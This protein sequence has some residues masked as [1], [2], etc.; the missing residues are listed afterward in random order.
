MNNGTPTPKTDYEKKLFWR[1]VRLYLVWGVSFI[2]CLILS[3]NLL[4]ARFLKQVGPQIN[5]AFAQIANLLPDLS[6]NEQTLTK[7]Y[8][9]MTENRNSA[10]QAGIGLSEADLESIGESVDALI[11]GC[12]DLDR[13]TRVKVGHD[14]SVIVTRKSDGTIIAHPDERFVGSK[15]MVSSIR[16]ISDGD[17]G[18]SSLKGMN[19]AE[20][21]EL[22]SISLDTF[23]TNQMAELF[24]LNHHFVYPS[25]LDTQSDNDIL[26][27][28][29]YASIV[30]YEDYYIVC[31]VKGI[32]YIQYMVQSLVISLLACVM[33]WVFVYYI[34]LLLDRHDE[35]A[36]SL[37]SQLMA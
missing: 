4:E 28:L 3:F 7:L 15:L 11:S 30:P 32:E 33:L 14:G 26:N 10:V 34:C 6:E 16:E 20:C 17:G 8:T 21:K 22:S 23:R 35:D 1:K 24:K 27:N 25:K 2:A 37:R 31:G 13:I 9:A 18:S 36:V 19:I 12:F 5:R 29:M